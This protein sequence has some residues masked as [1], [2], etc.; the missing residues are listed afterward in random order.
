ME[1]QRILSREKKLM[2]K[3]NKGRS[4]IIPDFSIQFR[5]TVIKMLSYWHKKSELY[6]LNKT[7]ILKQTHTYMD[8]WFCKGI[9]SPDI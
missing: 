7:M 6:E 1:S 8:I 3:N 2:E 4:L 9:K 5:A